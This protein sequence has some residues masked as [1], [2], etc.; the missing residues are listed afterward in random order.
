MLIWF[1]LRLACNVVLIKFCSKNNKTAT[2]NLFSRLLTLF[3]FTYLI[4]Y[5][6]IIDMNKQ[7]NQSQKNFI[8]TGG[9]GG[10]VYTFAIAI[11]LVLSIVVSVILVALNLS[12]NEKFLS[13]SF[14]IYL[15]F[16]LSSVALFLAILY[17][18]KRNSLDFKLSVGLIKC[19]K[20]YYLIA[21]LLAFAC[22]FG[23]GW[24]NDAFVAFLQKC[25]LTVSNVVLPKNNFGDF[26]AC[27]L[28]V[29]VMPA[30][31]EECIFRGLVLNGARRAGDLFA[32]IACA[33]L[34]SL[35][36]KNPSQT[37]YQLILGA[38]FALLTLKS[39]SILPATLVHFINNFYVVV[40]YFLTPDGYV[41][42][43][44]VQIVLGVLGIIVFVVTVLYLIFKTQKPQRFIDLDREYAKLSDKKFEAK[45]FIL[46]SLPGV[47]AC[48]VLWIVS[49]F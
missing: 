48:I 12:T 10:T 9:D 49:L 14:Y 47:I 30:F 28:I 21:L 23:L 36:H 1:N 40:Y 25:G 45:N 41:F 32:V 39:G 11:P 44:W 15:S 8:L 7:K 2:N 6:I 24:V 29:C 4:D 19:D 33:I 31:F 27:V 34:F 26:L 13:S 16:A 20:K 3:K 43:R 35:Y 17:F 38:V 22:L 46:F 5:S 18:C 42:D 37:V